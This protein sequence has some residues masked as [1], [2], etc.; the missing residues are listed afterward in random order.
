MI[1]L[2]HPYHFLF[3]RRAVLSLLV[4]TFC[5]ALPAQ[6]KPNKAE[7]RDL[8]LE[9]GA[10]G[11]GK[12]RAEDPQ[13]RILSKLREQLEVTD[14]EEWNV[15]AE[16]IIKVG[17]LRRGISSGGS[18]GRAAAAMTDKTKRS[19]RSTSG[20]PEQDSLRAALSDKLPD[21]EIKSRLAR[22]HE[23]YVQEEARLAKAQ[24]ELRAVLTIRQEAVVV[25]AGLLPP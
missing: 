19:N 8:K 13:A 25:M 17:E 4:V 7:R 10:A 18:S 16:R 5:S 23:A 6:T 21:A 22:V 1:P 15:I 20:R 14:D 24:E 12:P 2:A 9:A 11:E 3:G